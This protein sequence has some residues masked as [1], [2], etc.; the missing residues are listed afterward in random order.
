MKEKGEVIVMKRW[1]RK[2]GG[3]EWRS[4]GKERGDSDE[5]RG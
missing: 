2:E 4:E 3:V 1:N 5:E